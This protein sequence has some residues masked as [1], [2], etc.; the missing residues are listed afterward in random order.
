MPT[1]IEFVTFTPSDEYKS[2]E[3][4][5]KDFASWILPASKGTFMDGIARHGTRVEDKEI[6]HILFR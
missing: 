3:N 5:F 1:A 4:V 6:A 2:D